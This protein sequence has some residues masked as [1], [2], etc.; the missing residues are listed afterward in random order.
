V[1]SHATRSAQKRPHRCLTAN[2][3]RGTRTP[4]IDTPAIPRGH[5]VILHQKCHAEP[6]TQERRQAHALLDMPSAEKLMLEPLARSRLPR[7]KMNTS[8]GRPPPLSIAR[9]SLP[10]GEG[11]LHGKSCGN[12]GSTVSEETAPERIAVIWSPEARVDR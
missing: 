2:R 12:L 3:E 9:A 6:V 1:N 7:S 10:R 8:R 5:G 11:I 4:V